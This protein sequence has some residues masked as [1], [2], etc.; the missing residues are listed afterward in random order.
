M[1]AHSFGFEA[2]ARSIDLIWALM[3]YLSFQEGLGGSKA[4]NPKPPIVF[5]GYMLKR[6]HSAHVLR[7]RDA[8]K[9]ETKR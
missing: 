5:L 7:W 8:R 3:K 4:T 1:I 2:S 9:P 6:H